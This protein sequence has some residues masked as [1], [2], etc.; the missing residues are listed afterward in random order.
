M[1][2]ACEVNKPFEFPKR[3]RLKEKDYLEDITKQLKEIRTA[4]QNIK[5]EKEWYEKKYHEV[6]NIVYEIA[7]VFVPKYK[8]IES[9]NGIQACEILAKAIM[10]YA[11]KN[12]G[13]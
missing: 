12:N 10:E 13:V 7:D 5:K 4:Y 9:R 8:I 2:L 3:Q 11:P 1:T 6:C